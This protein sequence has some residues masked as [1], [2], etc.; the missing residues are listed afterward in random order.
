MREPRAANDWRESSKGNR[1][2]ARLS[3]RL[4]TLSLTLGIPPCASSTLFADT[5]RPA[6]VQSDQDSSASCAMPLQLTINALQWRADIRAMMNIIERN[7]KNPYHYASKANLEKAATALEIQVSG[8]SPEA[9][10]VRMAQIVALV[11][12]GHTRLVEPPHPTY[13][14][15]VY[16]FGKYLRITSATPDYAALVGGK[17]ERV[18]AYDV[19]A[20][21]ARLRSLIPQD[22]NMWLEMIGAQHS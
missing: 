6:I 11:G 18:G 1:A 3:F 19:A 8:L 22:E 12:D 14:I 21:R 13:P 2:L 9:I 10:P 16:W 5:P 15:R 4:F 20:V 7:H 17:L